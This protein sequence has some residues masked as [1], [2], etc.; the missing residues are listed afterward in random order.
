MPKDKK[1]LLMFRATGFQIYKANDKLEWIFQEPQAT[2]L[3]YRN[4]NEV[5]THSKGSTGPIWTDGKGSKVAGTLV[6]QERAPNA[7]AVP[8]LLLEAK[9]EN[10]DRFVK[11]THIQRVDTW[12]GQMPTSRPTKADETVKVPYQATYIFWGE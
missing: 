10:G 11:V 1:P 12:G 7:D 8:W 2:L 6:R 3:D 9:N 5:G 4:G